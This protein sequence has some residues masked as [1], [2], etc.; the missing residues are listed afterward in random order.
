[1]GGRVS[2]G[3]REV[4]GIE[5]VEYMADVYDSFPQLLDGE[6]D[7]YDALVAAFAAASLTTADL[8]LLDDRD[9]ASRCKR[10]IN[11]VERFMRIFRKK[12]M[13]AI[14]ITRIADQVG[15]K[16]ALDLSASQQRK[17]RKER[18]TTGDADFDHILGG[19]IP[20]QALTEIAGESASGKSNLLIQLSVTVQLP[21]EHGGLARP[22]IY[23]STESGVETRRINDVIRGIRSST[24]Y[25]ELAPETLPTTDAIHCFQCWSR[26]ELQHVL[27]YQLPVAVERFNAGLVIIDSIAAPFRGVKGKERTAALVS[28]GR[29]LR[30]LAKRYNCAVVIAN[31]VLDRW[32]VVLRMD[33]EWDPMYY[34]NQVRWFS[35]WTDEGI[36]RANITGDHKRRVPGSSQDLPSSSPP[37][38]KRLH[39]EPSS[40]PGLP[41]S[42]APSQ[43]PATPYSEYSSLRSRSLR[44]SAKTPALGML[45]STMLEQRIVLKRSPGGDYINRTFEVVFSPWVPPASVEFVISSS[46][47]RSLPSISD[48]D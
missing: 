14:K 23:I 21:P 34:N 22:A 1:M 41:P 20:T 45:W 16:S 33:Y 15:A 36:V 31:Q 48:L 18:F 35:G 47:L 17:M 6:E 44:G 24:D 29:Q 40:S 30:Q 5:L 4:T 12:S 28:M 9:I 13:D 27:R 39:Y 25:A 43:S 3:I 8:L 19:G 11:E 42:T 37:P 38:P 32:P 2:L 26:D 46:G 7:A 10:S